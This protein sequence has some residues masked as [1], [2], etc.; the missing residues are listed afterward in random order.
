MVLSDAP[1]WGAIPSSW[2]FAGSVH[3]NATG[4]I[5]TPIGPALSDNGILVL[6]SSGISVGDTL[7]TSVIEPGGKIIQTAFTT[8]ATPSTAPI[9]PFVGFCS[10]QITGNW[11][12]RLAL[13]NTSGTSDLT[14]FIFVG[15][16]FPIDWVVTQQNQLTVYPS[17][18]NPVF[19]VNVGQWL[20]SVGPTV[21][22][23]P[24]ANSLPVVIASDQSSLPTTEARL[25]SALVGGRLDANVG[26]WLGSTAPTVGAKASASS[27][28]V[29][30]ATDI[31]AGRS[32]QQTQANSLPVVAPSNGMG[33]G[34]SWRMPYD[35]EQVSQP[36]ANTQATIT[37]AA[38][39]NRRWVIDHVVFTLR[40]TGA[41][42]VNSQVA[43]IDGAA[44]IYGSQLVCTA[45][46]NSVDREVLGPNAAYFG[47]LGNAMIVRF[48]AAA[49]A[50]SVESITASGYL[51][52]AGV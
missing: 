17:V 21:G 38:T 19:N 2:R 48:A 27:I 8:R 32:G 11:T 15:P 41:V 51:L 47:T 1:D 10:A 50:T 44:T 14:A 24:G 46:A 25:P 35:S 39:A 4:S 12:L 7:F 36:A 5:D 26:S 13:V 3:L 40:Q 20:G 37:F 16:D 23:K 49:G 29:V 30:I 9:P 43:I 31:A 52:P 18:D 45:T 34:S 22:Q 42:A 6:C 33:P 28:P